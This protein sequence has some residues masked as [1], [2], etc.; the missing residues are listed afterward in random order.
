MTVGP[1]PHLHFAPTSSSLLHQVERWLSRITGQ[2]IQRGNFQAAKEPE[3]A[4][5]DYIKANN[6]DPNPFIWTMIVAKITKPS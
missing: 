5:F 1:A 2:R 3:Q 4:I 6:D